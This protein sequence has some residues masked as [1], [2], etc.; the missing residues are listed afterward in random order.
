MVRL[1]FWSSDW[2]YTLCCCLGLLTDLTHFVVVLVFWLILHTLLLSW[3]SDWSYTLCC[4]LG[5]L[6]DFTHFVICRS[7]LLMV[8]LL[9]W[10]SDLSYALSFLSFCASNGPSIAS[11]SFILVN[12]CHYSFTCLCLLLIY[13]TTVTQGIFPYMLWQPDG[14][15]QE[16]DFAVPMLTWVEVRW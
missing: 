10:S 4:C 12:T 7:E 3:S 5:L 11:H 2:S 14:W 9:S 1:L 8:R 13:V 15:K 16:E 6:T